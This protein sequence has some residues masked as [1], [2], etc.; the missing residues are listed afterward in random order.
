[1]EHQNLLTSN[2]TLSTPNFYFWKWSTG[3][4]DENSTSSGVHVSG[5]ATV[6]SVVM[7]Y[8]L[9]ETAHM[10]YGSSFTIRVSNNVDQPRDVIKL[11]DFVK[12]LVSQTLL[13]F[14]RSCIIRP[15][16]TTKWGGSELGGIS[17]TSKS[18]RR[19]DLGQGGS[20]YRRG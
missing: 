6:L 2:K 8:R 14:K 18:K 11:V 10:V 17:A 19:H 12:K 16:D 3:K 1:M 4:L 15:I 20:G 7:A 13:I 9:L 5:R